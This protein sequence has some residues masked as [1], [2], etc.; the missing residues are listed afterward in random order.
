MDLL[1]NSSPSNSLETLIAACELAAE[2]DG[3]SNEAGTLGNFGQMPEEHQFQ[4]YVD[5]GLGGSSLEAW[6][7]GSLPL[8]S[9]S[10]LETKLAT[11]SKQG[12]SKR[13][14]TGLR[15]QTGKG[16]DAAAR[17]RRHKSKVTTILLYPFRRLRL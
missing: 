1:T 13:H 17:Y 8:L 12:Q 16:G 2:Q 11:G 15:P 4:N 9:L 10:P 7:F 3:L 5:L 14:S 6:P